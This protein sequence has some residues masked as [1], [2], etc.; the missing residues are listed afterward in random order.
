LH[1]HAS[2]RLL[3][4]ILL[5]FPVGSHAETYFETAQHLLQQGQETEARR[6]LELEIAS[7]PRNLEAR[8]DLAVLLG[9]IGHN[10]E[11]DELYRKNIKLGRHLPSIVNL[12]ADLRQQGQINEAVALLKQA[13]HQFPAEAVPWYLL[14]E[15]A[16]EKGD[17]KQAASLYLNAIKADDKNGFA[18]LRYARFLSKHMQLAEATDQ[19]EKAV[20]LLP[21]CAPCLNIAGDI[22]EQAGN[23]KRALA[24]WQK[25]IAIEPDATLRGKILQALNTTR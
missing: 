16:E 3:A 14:A 19:A 21:A 22:F 1:R 13:T 23:K 18:H 24:L 15:I 7:R 2:R 11:A 10:K 5:L 9:R 8:Y 17:A 25:S 6:A 20:R 4:V 12:S